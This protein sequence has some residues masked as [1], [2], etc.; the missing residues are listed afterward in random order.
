M[1]YVDL[2]NIADFRDWP[3]DQVLTFE[4]AAA[5]SAVL[6]LNASAPTAVYWADNPEMENAQFLCMVE[7]LQEVR[8]TAPRT[9]HLQFAAPQGESVTFRTHVPTLTRPS[10]DTPVYTTVEP[11]NRRNSDYDRMMHLMTQN[12]NRMMAELEAERAQV[13]EERRKE[14]RK[15]RR[16]ERREELEPGVVEPEPETTPDGAAQGAAGGKEEEGGGEE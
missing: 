4:A 6:T 5:R 2:K 7:G 1:R 15:E 14:R 16:E 10:L 13:R 9:V 11:R 8:F 12:H 3:V